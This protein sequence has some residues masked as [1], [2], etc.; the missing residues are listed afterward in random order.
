MTKH[1][2]DHRAAPKVGRMT[3]YLR[4]ARATM[5]GLGWM[6]L[7]RKPVPVLASNR[8]TVEFARIERGREA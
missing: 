5:P 3:H 1:I 6:A 8:R 2:A 7:H 4:I